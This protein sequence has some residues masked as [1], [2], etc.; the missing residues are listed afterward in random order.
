MAKPFKILPKVN[1]NTYRSCLF[2]TAVTDADIGKPVKWAATDEYTICSD[3]DAI[4]GF[5]EALDSQIQGGKVFGTIQIAGTRC[6]KC[7]GAITMGNQV[8]AAAPSALNTAEAGKLA[9]VSTHTPAAADHK[10]W[11]L[12]SGTGLDTDATAVVSTL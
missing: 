6:V 9:L 11:R 1:E 3:G 7:S 2:T 4:D 12:I 10:K 8:E 5:I